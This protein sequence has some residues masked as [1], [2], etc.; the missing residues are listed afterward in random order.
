MKIAPTYSLH[1]DDFLENNLNTINS[2]DGEQ[3]NA[4]ITYSQGQRCYV[5]NSNIVYECVVSNSNKFPPDN[6]Y[7][8]S[9]NPPVG[10]WEQIGMT[11][12]WKFIDDYINS[13]SKATYSVTEN[14][15]LW[16]E[17][18]L[19]FNSPLAD[20]I[21]LFNIKA[22]KIIIRQIINNNIVI[23]HDRFLIDNN[24]ITDWFS[25]FF[26]DFSY[27]NDIS[28]PLHLYKNS[29]IEIVLK[30]KN[31][32][33][34]CGLLAIAKTIYIGELMYA[35]SL[36]IIDFSKK[37]NKEDGTIDLSQGK[38]YK[39]NS[40]DILVNTNKI[41]K[42]YKIFAQFRGSKVLFMPFS[43]NMLECM[44]V[45]GWYKDF[46]IVIQSKDTSLC[47]LELEGLV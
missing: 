36:S 8:D 44:L 12:R 3:W 23:E 4:S 33:A 10:Y 25:Y 21:S 47:T 17:I 42:I 7:N 11:N 2:D 45:Y 37:T 18:R 16:Y 38:Y 46:K 28:F 26:D 34:E 14:G 41:D 35:P 9:L 31:I 30:R 20:V 22:D 6:I 29:I 32:P 24:M 19:K 27:I 1:F 15:S 43:Y 40:Y 39:I 13:V 5:P